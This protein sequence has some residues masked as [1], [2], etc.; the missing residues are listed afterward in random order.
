MAN[1]SKWINGVDSL[2]FALALI[3]LLSHFETPLMPILRESASP[4]FQFIGE[5]IY[6]AFN[7]TAA[8]I[9]FFIISGFVIHHSSKSGI[10][11]WK[12]FIIK[13]YIRIILPLLTI[14]ILGYKFGSPEKG[15]LWSLICELVYYSLYP[16]FLA[17]K[18][19]W[20]KLCV[21]S[22]LL[23]MILMLVIAQDDIKA[24]FN[25]DDENFHGLYWQ[26]GIYLTWLVGLP[27]WLLGVII[28][29]KFDAYK[30]IS[31]NS[32]VLFRILIFLS[33][34]LLQY[35]RVHL[36]ISYII[37][38]N[39]YAILLYYWISN[40]ITYYKDKELS[41]VFEYL[42]KFS[43]SLY[44]THPFMYVIIPIFIP[45]TTYTYPIYIFLALLFSYTF[46][47]IIEKPSHNF[48]RS[49]SDSDK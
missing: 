37:S 13:R 31:F 11:N 5:L 28:A 17:L 30:K 10:R 4:L 46:Y 12:L 19:N 47:L 18:V 16:L 1:G 9:G 36:H 49:L 25:Q 40:E 41:S 21:Y 39:F 44:I 27:C 15:L 42:G 45:Y 32:L 7:G 2:R 14:S 34:I 35:T 26:A 22:F 38:M 29:E 43:Y 24:F 23:S 20:F 6:L 48:A 33:S 8:V 3:V